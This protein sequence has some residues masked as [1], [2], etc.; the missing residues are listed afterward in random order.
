MNRIVFCEERLWFIGSI[1][2]VSHEMCTVLL[3]KSV[4]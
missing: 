4:I 1:H 3:E 2:P